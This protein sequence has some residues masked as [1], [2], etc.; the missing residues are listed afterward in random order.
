M[1]AMSTSFSRAAARAS[2]SSD[3]RLP[4]LTIQSWKVIIDSLPGVTAAALTTA[5]V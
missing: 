1:V 3:S 5:R 2:P 4:P